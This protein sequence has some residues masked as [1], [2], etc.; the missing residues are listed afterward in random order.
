V[1]QRLR[2]QAVK[3]VDFKTEGFG[4]DLP[5]GKVIQTLG[6]DERQ[7]V[8]NM[9]H[10]PCKAHMSCLVQRLAMPIVVGFGL[11]VYLARK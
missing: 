7:K 11:D 5:P 1:E 3:I 8:D 4:K 2:W 9:H 10:T 6:G